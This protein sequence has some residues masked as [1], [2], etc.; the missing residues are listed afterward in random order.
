MEAKIL[1]Q[2]QIPEA[3]GIARGVFDYCLRTQITDLE[4]IHIFL[5][6]TEEANIRRMT[7][8][9][10]LTLWGIFEQGTMVA[11]SGMQSEG[12]ITM[13]Y[14]LPIFQKRGYGS[15]LLKEMRAYAAD[16]YGLSAVT[17]SAMPAWT[18]GY[19][20]KQKFHTLEMTQPCAFV[21]MQA[22]TIEQ[23]MYEKKPVPTA[24]MI[25]TSI[26]GLAVCAAIAVGYMICWMHGIV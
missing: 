15:C 3:L 4:M 26:G 5:Q 6:Y 24:V 7:E 19:F 23:A 21:P 1:S 22:K 10:K 16:Q 8:E 2:E 9:Q 12:H 25:G 18:E 14:V 11:M 17:L 20:A 13:L